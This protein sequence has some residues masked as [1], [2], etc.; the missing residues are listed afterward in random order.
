MTTVVNLEFFTI[1]YTYILYPAIE[2]DYYI[3]S[4]EYDMIITYNHP[5]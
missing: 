3:Y 1:V 2:T 5:M 4:I